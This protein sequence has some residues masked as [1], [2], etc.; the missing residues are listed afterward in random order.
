MLPEVFQEFQPSV[1]ENKMCFNLQ[2]TLRVVT[3]RVVRSFRQSRTQ[4]FHHYYSA[5]IMSRLKKS[6]MQRA[7]IVCLKSILAALD[8]GLSVSDI[9]KAANW[10]R[11]STS[12]K[13]YNRSQDDTVFGW[14]ILTS[15]EGR[16][17]DSKSH[18][19]V[20]LICPPFVLP[21]PFGSFDRIFALEE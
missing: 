14:A 10:S 18:S 8:S 21:H 15:R 3:L 6:R 2:I 19:R 11:E 13:F 4:H 20:G 12:N 9:L 7:S 1:K 17:Q 16:K 5:F